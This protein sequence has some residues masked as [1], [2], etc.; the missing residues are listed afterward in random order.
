[1]AKRL[2]PVSAL[3]AFLISMLGRMPRSFRQEVY[4]RL[5]R[6]NSL[7][8]EGREAAARILQRMGVNEES[9]LGKSLDTKRQFGRAPWVTSD[10]K[11]W[12]KEVAEIS[13]NKKLSHPA[14]AAD[15]L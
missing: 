7:R 3:D 6:Q 5:C 1:M 11:K 10:R 4:K 15:A 12:N 9:T 14:H 8:P 2:E 13:K